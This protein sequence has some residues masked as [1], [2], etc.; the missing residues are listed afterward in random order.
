MAPIS[1]IPKVHLAPKAHTAADHLSH[2]R[3]ANPFLDDVFKE[4][5]GVKKLVDRFHAVGAVAQEAK[6]TE[7]STPVTFEMWSHSKKSGGM[8]VEPFKDVIFVA[9][10]DPSGKSK[11]EFGGGTLDGKL[12]G[13]FRLDQLAFATEA[14]AKATAA[15]DHVNPQ[16]VQPLPGRF[17]LVSDDKTYVGS[18]EW[19]NMTVNALGAPGEKFKIN[20]AI[21]AIGADGSVKGGGWPGG[22]SGRT[23]E[24]T[25]GTA[26]HKKMADH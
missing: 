19:N 9:Q 11:L 24:G 18:Y 10:S 2:L 6:A 22:W 14:A 12:I 20:W 16:T 23:V 21:L 8:P 3:K 5:P 25:I 7:T 1:S 15:K 17:A 4:N 13:V 26:V